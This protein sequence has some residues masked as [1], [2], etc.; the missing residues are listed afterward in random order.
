MKNLTKKNIFEELKKHNTELEK[1][2][3]KKIGLFGSYARQEQTKKSDIDFLVEFKKPSFDNFMDLVFFL[4]KVFGKKVD[5]LTPMG[6]KSI[7][8]KTIKDDIKKSVIYG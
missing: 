3:V 7:S 6:V 1:Y 4:E 2:Q 8:I 5:V